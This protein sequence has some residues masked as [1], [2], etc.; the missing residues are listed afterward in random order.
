[1]SWKILLLVALAAVSSCTFYENN[2][3][4]QRLDFDNFNQ[5]N[6]GGIWLVEFYKPWCP[7]C[8]H[9]AVHYERIASVLSNVIN[10]GAFDVSQKQ[11]PNLDILAVPTIRLYV[12]R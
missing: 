7:H 3:D 8:Q 12:E 1:M 5:V 11:P 9:F 2:K 10:V 4:I 6:R